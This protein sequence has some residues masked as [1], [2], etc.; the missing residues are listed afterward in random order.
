MHACKINAPFYRF[1]SW[2]PIILWFSYFPS[3]NKYP[4]V[5]LPL[6]LTLQIC[7]CSLDVGV[8]SQWK[9]P[10]H[11]LC[12]WCLTEEKIVAFQ[13]TEIHLERSRGIQHWVDATEINIFSKQHMILG[14]VI[15]SLK[16]IRS[17]N[18][19]IN[20][21]LQFSDK[22]PL[23]SPDFLCSYENKVTFTDRTTY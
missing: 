10:V 3:S 20:W 17:E 22:S 12:C 5:P 1:L 11:C 21:M 18:C 4:L 7:K 8:I 19:S 16:E 9:P 13:I 15:N 2:C 14:D 6:S 23:T